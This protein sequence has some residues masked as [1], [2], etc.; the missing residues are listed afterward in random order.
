[1]SATLPVLTRP[2]LSDNCY[3]A[4][5]DSIINLDLAP[6]SLIDENDIAG[7]FGIS[8]TPVRE[9]LARLVGERFV[10]M[11]VDRKPLV[12]DLSIEMIRDVYAVRL[13]LEPA[14]LRTVAPRLT[15]NMIQA[16]AEMVRTAQAALAAEDTATF[17]VTNEAFHK[18]LIQ[19][20]GN[21]CLIDLTRGLFDQADRIRAAIHRVEQQA[22]YRSL[23]ARGLEHHRQIVAALQARD[24]AAAAAMMTADIQ[25]FLDAVNTSEM[26]EAFASLGAARQ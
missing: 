26:Q 8:K 22:M 15:D 14:S 17:I 5:K 7:Q 13:M 24:A 19:H 4:L 25:L 16:L 10:I 9:A 18:S 1:M 6:G 23:T 21:R 12:A 2:T 11:G 3:Q 20:S